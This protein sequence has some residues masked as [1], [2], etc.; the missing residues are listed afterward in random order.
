MKNPRALLS[1]TSPLLLASV[2]ALGCQKSQPQAASAPSAPPPAAEP[3]SATKPA[4][5]AK[6]AE[7]P[8]AAADPAKP[9]EAPAAAPADPKAVLLA[10]DKLTAEAPA[11]YKVKFTTTK[12]DFVI[13][14]HRDWAPKGA[15]RFYNLVQNGY[16]DEN[17]FFRVLKGFMVQFGINGEPRVNDAWQPARIEDDPVKQS[18]K[19]GYITFAK[20]SAPNSRTTQVFINF[21]D[22]TQLDGMGFAPFGKVVSGQKAVD[23]I[24]TEYG[25]TPNQMR[26]Q[27]QGNRYLD[28]DFPKLDHIKSAKILK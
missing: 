26:I 9:A 21:V 24:N 1:L 15:D 14:V 12:G 11:K 20:S 6:P 2:L 28:Q 19:R 8:P 22:N 23:A 3:P 27:D 7:P 13:E 4:E 16:Y 5:P 17:R 18:N 25:E 10:P